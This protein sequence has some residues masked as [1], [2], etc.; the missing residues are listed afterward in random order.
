MTRWFA[1]RLDRLGKAR[2]PIIAVLAVYGTC[3]LNAE[4]IGVPPEYHIKYSEL[5]FRGVVTDVQ[6]LKTHLVL[7]FRVSR[8]WKGKPLKTVVIYQVLGVESVRFPD[9]SVGQEYLILATALRD[10]EREIVQ[11]RDAQAFGIPQCT[12]PISINAAAEYLKKLGSGRA[13]KMQ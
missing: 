1:R 7:T 4:C 9:N 12:A 8:V 5:I 11:T 10:F 3:S 13:P 2:L 6:D